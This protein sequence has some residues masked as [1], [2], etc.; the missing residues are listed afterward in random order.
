[1]FKPVPLFRWLDDARPFL[2]IRHIGTEET[3]H[4]RIGSFRITRL[5]RFRRAYKRVSTIDY[6]DLSGG[7]NCLKSRRFDDKKTILNSR[8]PLTVAVQLHQFR[9]QIHIN[10]YIVRTQNRIDF[11]SQPH[12]SSFKSSWRQR[13]HWGYGPLRKRGLIGD[14]R[15]V[16]FG[17][18]DKFFDPFNFCPLPTPSEDLRGFDDGRPLFF[19]PFLDLISKRRVITNQP[20][21]K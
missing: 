2:S 15:R 21:F 3:Q 4:Q 5:H 10:R 17:G 16:H 18:V 6:R 8:P 14:F 7:S 20:I 9:R 1:M 19:H 13:G 12:V 11:Q